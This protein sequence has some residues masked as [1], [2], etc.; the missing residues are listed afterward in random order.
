M[1]GVCKRRRQNATST[2]REACP[3]RPQMSNPRMEVASRDGFCSQVVR[4]VGLEPTRP[5][6]QGILSPL[7]LPFRHIRD[8]M[9][10]TGVPALKQGGELRPRAVCIS[11]TTQRLVSAVKWYEEAFGNRKTHVARVPTAAVRPG[12]PKPQPLPVRS[13][14]DFRESNRSKIRGVPQGNRR[15]PSVAFPPNRA[16]RRSVLSLASPVGRLTLDGRRI[17]PRAK[18]GSRGGTSDSR[19]GR[20]VHGEGDCAAARSSRPPG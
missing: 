6:G 1:G 7:R 4:M 17:R 10:S 2:P 19:R 3:K 18:A 9:H 5:C 16:P 14:V 8:T 20:R 15:Q 12:S 13:L 11:A